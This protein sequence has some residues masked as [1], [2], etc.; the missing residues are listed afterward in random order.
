MK[1]TLVIFLDQAIKDTVR[2]AVAAADGAIVEDGVVALDGLAAL[3]ALETDEVIAIA[4][5]VD[6][7]T[8]FMATPAK[9]EAQAR[10]SAPFLIED[11]VAVDV[12]DLHVALGTK[13]VRPDAPRLIGWIAENAMASLT[14]LLGEGLKVAR[15]APDYMCLP[16]AP[17]EVV[18]IEVADTALVRF[19][20]AGGFAIERDLAADVVPAALMDADWE[21]VH[22]YTDDKAF[23][24]S[25]SDVAEASGRSIE[26]A[27]GLSD[28]AAYETLAVGASAAPLTLLQGKYAPKRE[29]G[30]S[31][32][33]W[34]KAAAL[35]ASLAA[36][37]IVSAMSEGF[38]YDRQ[39]N[40]MY[41]RAEATYTAAFPQDQIRDPRTDLPPRMRIRLSEFRGG[42][43]PAFL[44]LAVVLSESTQTLDTVKVDAMRF[45]AAQGDL[46]ANIQYKDFSDIEK[47]KSEIAARGARLEEGRARQDGSVI[48][49][50]IIVRRAS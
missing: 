10:I 34:R 32:R 3:A 45:D 7:S 8:A 38:Y 23:A 37:V 48:A 36:V 46:R 30:A 24:S 2:W 4:P 40:R 42:G 33:V 31:V 15:L 47:L 19:G 50:E 29:L 1:R 6:V 5:G 13:P 49:G 14:G 17:G 12:A 21:T 44:Q 25:V 20:D 43:G 11:D 28:R 18:I 26:T 41:K 39:A 35:A 16:A 22:L 9:S 27:P